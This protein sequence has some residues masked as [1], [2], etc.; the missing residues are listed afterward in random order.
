MAACLV[1]TTLADFGVWWNSAHIQLFDDDDDKD[2]KE[3]VDVKIKG[4]NNLGL[5]METS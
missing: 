2:K 3:D 5:E 1:L 4:E